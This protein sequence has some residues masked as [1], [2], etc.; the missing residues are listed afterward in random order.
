MKRLFKI[1]IYLLAALLSLGSLPSASAAPKAPDFT[2]TG[3]DGKTYSLSQYQ[4]KELVLYF[5]ATWCPA[6]RRDAEYFRKVYENYNGKAAE[7][8]TVSLDKDIDKLKAFIEEKKIPY[9]VLF[10]GKSWDNP[11]AEAYHIDSTPSYILISKEGEIVRKGAFSSE[12]EADLARVRD[13]GA[14]DF[15]VAPDFSGTDLQ[16]IHHSLAD[17]KGKKLVLYF[18]ATWCP[19]CRQDTANIRNLIPDLQSKG[20]EFVS[21]SLD[22]ELDKLQA[23]VKENEITFPVLFDGKSWDDPNVIAYGMHSTPSYVLISPT[24]ALEGTG[25]WSEEIRAALLS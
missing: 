6:C 7:I 18:W 15:L 11:I 13:K 16:G 12:L 4:G 25:H 1:K 21:V 2:G 3:V 17:Y 24:G 8:L 19:A 22:K 20:V 23:Y 5:W 9:P 14:A 10:G